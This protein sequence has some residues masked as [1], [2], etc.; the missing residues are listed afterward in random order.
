MHYGDVLD[1]FFILNLMKQFQPDEVYN[2]AAQSHVAHS[3]N[4]SISTFEVN[5]RSIWLICESI[6]TL[7]LEKKTSVFHASTSEMYG[8]HRK[9]V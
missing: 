3:F 1:P 2:F 9:G 5:T 8:D 7:G 6:R 4:G